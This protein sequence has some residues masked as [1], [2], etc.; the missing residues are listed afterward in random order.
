MKSTTMALELDAFPGMVGLFGM[1]EIYLGMWLRGVGF[2][3]YSAGLYATICLAL[4]WPGFGFLW[5]YLPTEWGIGYVLETLDIFRV[6][7][8]I[9]D[10]KGEKSN[11]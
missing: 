6:T 4:I 3:L 2:L 9:V 1:G 10:S 5:G 7:D 8:R 11:P